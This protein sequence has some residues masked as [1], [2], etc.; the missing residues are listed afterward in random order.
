MQL[1]KLH[2]LNAFAI[3][4]FE[5]AHNHQPHA[6]GNTSVWNQH[7]QEQKKVQQWSPRSDVKSP[8][9]STIQTYNYKQTMK[10]DA[11][12]PVGSKLKN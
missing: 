4:I 12:R 9:T 3:L 2:L 10:G 7:K 1:Y 8:R 5:L 6:G 11:T